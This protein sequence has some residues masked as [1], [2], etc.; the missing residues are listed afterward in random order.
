MNQLVLAVR[1]SLTLAGTSCAGPADSVCVAVGGF[2]SRPLPLPLPLPFP[3][4]L[5]DSPTAI[6]SMSFSCAV[7][8]AA[9]PAPAA[10]P[11]ARLVAANAAPMALHH[12][13]RTY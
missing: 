12:T 7:I 9:P 2:Q 3:A 8:A 4:A 5:A 1:S 13:N 10:K 11:L 6:R